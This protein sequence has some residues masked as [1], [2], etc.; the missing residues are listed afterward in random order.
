MRA[1]PRRLRLS[2]HGFCMPAAGTVPCLLARL[3]SAANSAG[4][5]IE[6]GAC[7]NEALGRALCLPVCHGHPAQAPS[8][9]PQPAST[10]SRHRARADVRLLPE[11]F[12][13]LIYA[14]LNYA[15]PPDVEK[16][17]MVLE[18]MEAQEGMPAEGG[19]GQGGAAGWTML[20]T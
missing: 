15:R 6:G 7:G 5:G 16:A 12:V 9:A 19:T 20:C 17:R 2:A 1:A 14:M 13:V 10:L 3:A 11:T 8:A 18:S 4:Q